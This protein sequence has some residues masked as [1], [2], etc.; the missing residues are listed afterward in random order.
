MPKVSQAHLDARRMQILKSARLCFA[1]QGFHRTTM[2]HIVR[3]SRLSP[4]AI[5]RYFR[6]KDEIVEALA[7][8]R[9]AREIKGLTAVGG[10]PSG[11]PVIPALLRAFFEPLA[12]DK[13]E[14]VNRRVVIQVWAESLRSPRIL[15][16][17]RKN[18]N[19]LRGLLADI[20]SRGQRN[21]EI[22]PDLDPDAVARVV[23]GLLQ[24]YYLH[25]AWDRRIGA[26]SYVKVI[27]AIFAGLK[28]EGDT[29]K[30][31]EILT[32]GGRHG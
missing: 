25:E 30:D 24:S 12:A 27:A 20:I 19:S 9:L 22:R 16:A 26:D 17:V 5:Y 28:D 31:A 10:E 2:Q 7:A 23:I 6:S 11:G 3:A 15:R 13:Q 18:L 4:G 8:K 14:R 21:G 32:G 1:R 29:H